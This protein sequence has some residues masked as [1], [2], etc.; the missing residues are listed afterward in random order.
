LPKKDKNFLG[1][2]TFN[3]YGFSQK[4]FVFIMAKGL[5]ILISSKVKWHKAQEL[6]TSQNAA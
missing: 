5:N 4:F 6:H 3:N 2:N 1:V